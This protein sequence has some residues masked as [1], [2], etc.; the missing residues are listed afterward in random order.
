M[1]VEPRLRAQRR[2]DIAA[3]MRSGDPAVAPP[4]GGSPCGTGGGSVPGGDHVKLER[5]M[6]RTPAGGSFSKRQ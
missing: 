3:Q 2:G 4:A 1:I 6:L 5:R